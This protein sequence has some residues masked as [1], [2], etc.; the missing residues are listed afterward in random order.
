M[1]SEELRLE[2]FGGPESRKDYENRRMANAFC[3]RALCCYAIVDQNDIAVAM[4]KLQASEQEAA[5]SYSSVTVE[6]KPV[7]VA[8]AQIVN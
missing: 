2:I 1:I 7:T 5:N 8:K 6:E 4:K 3:V